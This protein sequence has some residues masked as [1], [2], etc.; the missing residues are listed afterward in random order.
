LI[1]IL[2]ITV[3]CFLFCHFNTPR[4]TQQLLSGVQRQNF[5]QK[6]TPQFLNA[7]VGGDRA[8]GSA[9]FGEQNFSQNK[10]LFLLFLAENTYC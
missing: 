3:I 1:N 4:R 6:Q 9:E 8:L 2:N 5:H 7:P 10:I